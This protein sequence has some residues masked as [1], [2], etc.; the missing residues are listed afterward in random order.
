MGEKLSSQHSPQSP[1]VPSSWQREPHAAVSS[2]EKEGL[3]GRAGVRGRGREWKEDRR[4]ER[5]K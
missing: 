2:M 3:E 5:R 4:K 1:T